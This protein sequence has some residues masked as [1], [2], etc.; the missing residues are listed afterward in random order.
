MLQS[1]LTPPWPH[2]YRG[3]LRETGYLPD[4]IARAYIGQYVRSSYRKL[5]P[6]A[7][8][9]LPESPSVPKPPQPALEA[10][11]PEKSPTPT[12]I[13]RTQPPSLPQLQRPFLE[14]RARQLLSI[15]RRANEGYLRPLERVLM[16]AYGRAGR[17]RYDLLEPL[18]GLPEPKPTKKNKRKNKNRG[19]DESIDDR[20]RAIATAR[21]PPGWLPPP[22][23]SELLSS[24][25]NNRTA[26]AL[27]ITPQPPKTSGPFGPPDTSLAGGG[28]TTRWG[29]PLGDAAIE[30]QRARWFGAIVASAQP[31]MGIEE[32][33][34]L[35]GLVTGTEPWTAPVRRPKGTEGSG[36]VEKEPESQLTAHMLV[37]GPPKGFT[38]GAYAKGRPHRLTRRL[39]TRMWENVLA[40]TP[41]TRWDSE[42]ARWVVEWGH[43]ENPAPVYRGIHPELVSELFGGVDEAGRI[44]N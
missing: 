30:R 1:S 44:V 13:N 7:I 28:R 35:Y 6:Y 11:S 37:F 21:P 2:V 12:G 25:A 36:K 4:P 42:G 34:V 41:R 32:W 17:R 31:P 16:I 29:R 22:L 14:R 5:A 18:L 8:E 38:F 24:Q 39:M 33:E 40:I 26:A 19:I 10:R 23:L 20:A 3:L 27:R 9:P 43:Y 15:L